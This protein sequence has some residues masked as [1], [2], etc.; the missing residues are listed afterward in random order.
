MFS[1][2]GLYGRGVLEY[3]LEWSLNT[4]LQQ[5]MSFFKY[6]MILMKYVMV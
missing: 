6:K 4:N 1:Y 3:I 2:R 5:Q